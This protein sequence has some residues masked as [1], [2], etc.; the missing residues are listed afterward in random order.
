MRISD[1]LALKPGKLVSVPPDTAI[2]RAVALMAS[3]HVGALVVIDLEGRLLGVVSEHGVVDG[4]ARHGVDLLDRHVTDIM[5]SD[6]PIVAPADTVVAAMRIMTERRAR[7][8]P[9]VDDGRLT[10]LVS[11]GD[12]LKSRLA[13]KAEEVTVLQDIAR[14]RLAAA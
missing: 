14:F 10:G 1:I 8:L 13:E 7:H 2:R 12:V 3:E 6:G 9:V 5:M 4:L 11:V